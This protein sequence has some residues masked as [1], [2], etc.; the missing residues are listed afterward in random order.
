MTNFGLYPSGSGRVVNA[1]LKVL[2]ADITLTNPD[3]FE[4]IP[5]PAGFTHL[6]LVAQLRGVAAGTEDVAYLFFN[7]DTTVANYHWQQFGMQNGTS[8]VANEGATP[9]LTVVPAAGS[10]AGFFGDVRCS[11]PNCAGS[12]QKS[13]YGLQM[14][15]E[16]TDNITIRNHS[17]AWDVAGGIAAITALTVRTN[18]HPTDLFTAGSRVQVFGLGVFAVAL[19][20]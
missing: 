19:A 12:Q 4:S 1:E 6:E 3:S 5:I 10:P 13:A 8:S 20:R 11:I 7:N 18:N 2:I 9:I 15:Y 14:A 16:A 17:I